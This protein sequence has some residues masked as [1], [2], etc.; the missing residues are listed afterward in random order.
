M[1]RNIPRG[2]PKG[3]KNNRTLA[4]GQILEKLVPDEKLVRLLWKLAQKGDARCI[5]YLADRKW[6][7]Q[8]RP[9]T[10][11]VQLSGGDPVLHEHRIVYVNQAVDEPSKSAE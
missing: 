1:A 6:G 2:R 4:L 5:T 7:L 10:A 3:R 8:A 11:D 9:V